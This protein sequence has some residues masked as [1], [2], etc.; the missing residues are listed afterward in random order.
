MMDELARREADAATATTERRWPA[1]D[2]TGDG[3]ADGASW[4]VDGTSLAV[5]DFWRRRRRAA[6]GDEG[7]AGE[8]GVCE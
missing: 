6:T 4:V 5:D 7:D 3:D 8:R 1:D 2:G